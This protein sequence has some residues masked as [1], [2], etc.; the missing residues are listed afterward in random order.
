M[1]SNMKYILALAVLATAAYAMK[2][3]KEDG[4]ICIDE[5]T[6]GAICMMGS[7]LEEKYMAAMMTCMGDGK[8]VTG[9]QGKGNGKGN[10][11]TSG[12]GKNSGKTSGK[13]KNSGNGK[14]S[15]KTSGKG[16]N[17]GKGKGN[18]KG[19]GKGGNNG[20]K[21]PAFNEIIMMM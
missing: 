9:R 8:V 7:G 21:C 5:E 19:K 18:G 1:G 14:N 20:G 17:S 11:K 13:G 12:N 10:G 3:E 6:A 4:G 15:G 16:K 2:G